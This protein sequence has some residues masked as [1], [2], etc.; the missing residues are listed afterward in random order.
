MT[1]KQVT[2]YADMPEELVSVI[3]TIEKLDRDTVSKHN[4]D[5]IVVHYKRNVETFILNHLGAQLEQQL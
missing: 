3:N 5:I 4:D 2:R 1:D